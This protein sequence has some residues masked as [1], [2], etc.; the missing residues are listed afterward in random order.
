MKQLPPLWA[1]QKTAVERSLNEPALALFFETGTG[2]TRTAI[3]II[4]WRCAKEQKLLKILILVPKIIC[5]NWKREIAKYSKIAEHDVHVLLGAGA[6]RLK[7]FEEKTLEGHQLNRPGIFITNYEALEMSP[8]FTALTD[9]APDMMIIDEAH[10]IKNPEATRAKKC[11]Q[12]SDKVKYK[13]ALTGTPILNSAMDVFNIFRFLDN[14]ETFGVNFWK[15]RLSWF[16]DENAGWNN[17]PGYFPKWVPRAETYAE[18]NKLIYR[19]AI[20]ALKKDCIDLPPFVRKEV[21]V[22]LSPEQKRLYSEMRDEYVAYID[23]L[24]KTDTPRAVVAQLAVTKA[25]RLQQIVTG[26]AKTEDGEIHRIKDNPRIKALE[27]L[28]EDLAPDHKVIVWSVF[29][30]NYE[31]IANVCKVLKLKYREVHGKVK[32]KDRQQAI[33]D[34]NNDPEVRVFIGNQRAG[35]IGIELIPS[36]VSIYFSKNFSREDDEQSEARN[37]RGG[38]HIHKSVTRIDL[39]ATDTID[40]LIT[41]ALVN[42]KKISDEILDW[43]TK[44]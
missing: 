7:Y 21:H 37:F 43:K 15:F 39:V 30:E 20:R 8:L 29:H 32:D 26:Y 5:V 28:L 24:T 33:D 1:H 16:E 25:L 18:F 22:E 23:D 40:D 11:I 38:S 36:D 3:D 35:G 34:F 9:W 27:E 2:K 31:E 10:R 41:Q 17:R 12:L 42:K 19:K 13:Y 44:L 4:R 6:K 14:G